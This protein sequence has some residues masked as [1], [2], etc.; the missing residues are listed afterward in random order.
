[1]ITRLFSA[2]WSRYH[3]GDAVWWTCSVGFAA[4]M[5]HLYS[6]IKSPDVM[7]AGI[8]GTMHKALLQLV[9]RH[10]LL[11]ESFVGYLSKK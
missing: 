3:C 6:K 5:R 8:I 1:L 11:F 9:W 2:N 7:A 10:S 4:L